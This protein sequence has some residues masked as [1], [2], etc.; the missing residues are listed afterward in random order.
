MPRHR[1]S[2][3]ADIFSISSASRS[4]SKSSGSL[5]EFCLISVFVLC[6]KSGSKYRQ[7]MSFTKRLN[8]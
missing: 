6:A 1:F 8:K 3:D 5:R 2:V 7:K 4:D